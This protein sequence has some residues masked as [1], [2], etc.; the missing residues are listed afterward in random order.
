[1]AAHELADNKQL[2]PLEKQ[3]KVKNDMRTDRFPLSNQ[4]GIPILEI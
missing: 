4:P 1:M 2:G 3:N